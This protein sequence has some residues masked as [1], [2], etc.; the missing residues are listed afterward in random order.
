MNLKLDELLSKAYS[1]SRKWII[2]DIN[3]ERRKD[4]TPIIDLL[5][6]EILHSIN[7]THLFVWRA[8]AYDTIGEFSKAISDYDNVVRIKETY[9]QAYSKR[10]DLWSKIGNKINAN[11]DYQKAIELQEQL[12]N[13]S[14][15]N[16]QANI[17]LANKCYQE[18][19]DLYNKAI[20]FDSY[21]ASLYL[22]RSKAF[23]NLREFSI[24]LQDINNAIDII[25]KKEDRSFNFSTEIKAGCSWYTKGFYQDYLD[26]EEK[27]IPLHLSIFI[28]RGLCFEALDDNQEAIK[29]YRYVLSLSP[30]NQKAMFLLNFITKKL[31]LPS[32]IDDVRNDEKLKKIAESISTLSEEEQI[33]IMSWYKLHVTKIITNIQ[34]YASKTDTMW[35]DNLN[36]Y[37]S[38]YTNLKTVDKIITT[39]NSRMRYSNAVFMNDPDEGKILINC[40]SQIE[41]SDSNSIR[42]QE[43]FNKILVEEKNNFYIGSF[44]PVINGHEDELLMWRTYGKDEKQNDAAGC[45]IILDSTFFD[46]TDGFSIALRNEQSGSNQSLYKVLYYN[47][48]EHKFVGDSQD[49]E[50]IKK[51]IRT[52]KDLLVALLDMKRDNESEQNNAI[53]RVIYHTLSELRYFFKSSDFSYENELRVIQFIS[54]KNAIKVDVNSEHL[55]RKVYVESNKEVIPYLRKIILGPKVPHPSRWMYLEHLMEQKNFYI[56]TVFSNCRFQ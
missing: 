27:S 33:E 53:D 55:P 13:T 40:I 31:D 26:Y 25:N 21:S 17:L 29:D 47:Q 38:H 8:I 37:V 15:L 30:E 35:A 41:K 22:N 48:R 2:D 12:K 16:Y 52:L 39:D 54:N 45:C 5:S 46:E 6:D 10:G 43:A 42:I 11:K 51:N 36:R 7:C 44:L 28:N 50:Q 20:D 23:Y 18:A 9:P 24:A 32:T 3:S 49:N 19:I 14:K 34:T 1:I 56:S 4:F